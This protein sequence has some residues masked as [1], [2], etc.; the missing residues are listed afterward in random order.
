MP[1]TEQFLDRNYG[2]KSVP[3]KHTVK[4][5]AR[6]ARKNG[7]RHG[8]LS[9]H[10]NRVA[11]VPRSLLFTI[12]ACDV[13]EPFDVYWKVRNTGTEAAKV[14]QL[15]GEI[16]RDN[17]TRTKKEST[18]YRGSHY[19]ECYVVKN[20]VSVASTKQLVYVY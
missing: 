17:G 19:V 15:R 8:N 6:I 9:A 5:G 16:T 18:A 2:I 1:T 7:F 4:I 20:G 12:T 10:G 3:S 14:G 13:P 11:K